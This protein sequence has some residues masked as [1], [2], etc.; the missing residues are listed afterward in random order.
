MRSG[1]EP[2]P[3]SGAKTPETK[4]TKELMST[5]N[6]TH[7]LD[8]DV[9]AHITVSIDTPMVRSEVLSNGRINLY[10]GGIALALTPLS[11]I[12]VIDS[13]TAAVTDHFA[14]ELVSE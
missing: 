1:P 2:L 7:R 4:E 5:S 6:S 14:P 9:I 11:V 12:K 3:R 13:L 10:V 8:S